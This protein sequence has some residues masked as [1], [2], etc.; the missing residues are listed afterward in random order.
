MCSA[1][2]PAP[3]RETLQAVPNLQHVEVPVHPLREAD[4][5]R[6]DG[7]EARARE[8]GPRDAGELLPQFPPEGALGV[9]AVVV[10]VAAAGAADGG[11]GGDMRACVSFDGCRWRGRLWATLGAR[12]QGVRQGGG[13]EETRRNVWSASRMAVSARIRTSPVGDAGSLAPV[14]LLEYRRIIRGTLGRTTEVRELQRV[15]VLLR[16]R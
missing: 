5:R 3:H 10:V 11:R 4:V 16:Q 13:V 8:L 6:R 15:T 14:S 9:E 2:L 1:E 12:L 7:E